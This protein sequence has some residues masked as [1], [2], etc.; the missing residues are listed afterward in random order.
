MGSSFN[1]EKRKTGTR[2][3]FI[4]EIVPS[5]PIRLVVRGIIELY[6]D[7]WPNRFFFTQEKI[8]ML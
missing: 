4:K 1:P 3:S 8:N 5:N 2:K 6:G 7:K